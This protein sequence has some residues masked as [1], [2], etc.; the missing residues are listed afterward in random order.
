[1]VAARSRLAVDVNTRENPY[2]GCGQSRAERTTGAVL[3]AL[4]L[5]AAVERR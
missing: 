2:V 1:M 3:I 4:A 5:R